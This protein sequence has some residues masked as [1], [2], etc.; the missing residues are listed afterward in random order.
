MFK[1]QKDKERVETPCF[2][3]SHL[4]QVASQLAG[5]RYHFLVPDISSALDIH[6][7][8]TS[9]SPQ[10]RAFGLKFSP[11]LR[12]PTP[13]ITYTPRATR[14]AVL[15]LDIWLYG[16]S[17]LPPTSVGAHVVFAWYRVPACVCVCGGRSGGP[18]FSDSD[19]FHLNFRLPVVFCF[20]CILSQLMNTHCQ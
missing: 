9:Q 8:S 18:T 3:E 11:A 20:K 1:S 14:H 12:F 13:P 2:M 5:R 16:L 17:R 19:I 6:S 4:P 10:I 7:L 15:G